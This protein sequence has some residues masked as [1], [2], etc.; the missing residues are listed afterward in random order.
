MPHGR[1][2]A[3]LAIVVALQVHQPVQRPGRSLQVAGVD[4]G[5]G[6]GSDAGA[7]TGAG[8]GAVSGAVLG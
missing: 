3:Y 2:E 8:A 7:G 4:A 6:A 1:L 5:V